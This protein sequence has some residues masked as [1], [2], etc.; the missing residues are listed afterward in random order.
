MNCRDRRAPLRKR[1]ASRNWSWL[2]ALLVGACGS[3]EPSIAPETASGGVPPFA[4]E[5]TTPESASCDQYCQ[6]VMQACVGD[7]AVY[8]NADVC[9]AVCATLAPG[10]SVE[11]EGNSVAC[12]AAHARLAYDEPDTQCRAAGPGGDGRCGS[13]CEAYCALYPQIC[14]A[15]ASAQG[16]KRDCLQSCQALVDQSRFNVVADH[17]GDTVECRL[18]HVSA[19]ALEPAV[20]CAHAQLE[21][22]EPW[23]VTA[24]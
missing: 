17:G 15:E 5:E 21:P 2:G 19:A 18:V 1:G 12:R 20:H 3:V 4:T 9:L 11:A 14:P 13:D 16:S 6:I 22:T 7:N 23:C 24:L 10:D 8:V